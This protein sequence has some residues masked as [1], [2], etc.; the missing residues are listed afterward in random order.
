MKLV[1]SALFSPCEEGGYTVTVPALPGC[2]TEGDT[3]SEAIFMVQD[4]ASAWVLDELEEGRMA[5]EDS[6]PGE[7]VPGKGEFVSLIALDMDSYSEKYGRK[8]VRKNVTIPA[9]LN[10]YGESRNLNF[11]QILADAL[12]QRYPN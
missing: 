11:S 5:P 10:T 8:A 12:Q 4:A 7:I 6:K 3:L 9:W 2:V 1:Y